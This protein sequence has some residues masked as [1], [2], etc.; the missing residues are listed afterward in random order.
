MPKSSLATFVIFSVFLHLSLGVIFVPVFDR[1]GPRSFLYSWGEFPG[2]QRRAPRTELSKDTFYRQYLLPLKKQ[3]PSDLTKIVTDLVLNKNIPQSP[4]KNPVRKKTQGYILSLDKNT[5]AAT[6]NLRPLL[7]DEA[8]LRKYLTKE[9]I[10]V[11]I[12]VSPSGRPIW[13]QEFSFSGDFWLRFDL[14]DWIRG[15]VFEPKST[16]YWKNLEIV[17][18]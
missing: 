13:V 18:Q 15:L 8:S 17:L 5:A 3:V 14:E 11:D 12:L 6:V 10:S 9:K 16:Y 2:A 7:A 4:I 1:P